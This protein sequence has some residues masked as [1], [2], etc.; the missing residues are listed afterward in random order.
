M[1]LNHGREIVLVIPDIHIP[2]QH[3]DAFDFLQCVS[4]ELRP[5]RVV[6]IGD[7]LDMH[8]LSRFVHDPD[9][10][11]AGD[12]YKRTMLL[13]K[14]LYTIFPDVVEVESTHNFR[15]FKR[16]FE[17]G[18]PKILLK[19]YR[20]MI[21]APEGWEFVE[22]VEIDGILYEHGI[23]FGGANVARTAATYNRKSTVIGHHHTQGGICY[24]ANRKD[25]IFGMSVGCLIDT[26]AYTFEYAHSNKQK[27]VLM[28]GGVFHGVPIT[29]PMIL[30]A[31]GRWIGKLY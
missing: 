11:S 30:N 19:E 6:S 10:M 23:S 15:V 9:G 13:L 31:K 28:C 2:F 4:E 12:E 25:L 21:Q 7:S 17:A 3:P 14:Q 5:T 29:Y 16:A 18:I 22:N 26:G 1:Q 8:A 24:L 20:D 27:Q